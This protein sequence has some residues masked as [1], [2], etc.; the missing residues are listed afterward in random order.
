MEEAVSK[1]SESYEAR[2][3]AGG[4]N[5]IIFLSITFLAVLVDLALLICFIVSLSIGDD[6]MDKFKTV[7]ICHIVGYSIIV[8]NEIIIVLFILTFATVFGL[9]I[10]CFSII[11]IIAVLYEIGITIWSIILLAKTGNDN[12]TFLYVILI[13]QACFMSLSVIQAICCRR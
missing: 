9:I 8:F 5:Y 11:A 12:V 10:A 7:L 3:K 1:Q 6:L 13:I 4:A 2:K